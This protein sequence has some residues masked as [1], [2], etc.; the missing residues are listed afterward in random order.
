MAEHNT[1]TGASLHEPKGVETASAKQIYVADGSGGGEWTDIGEAIADSHICVY[2]DPQNQTRTFTSGVVD[3]IIPFSLDY[4][5]IEIRNFTWDNTA[6]ELT[7]TGT[8]N[9][10]STINATMSL[11]LVGTGSPTLKFY[12]QKLNGGVWETNYRSMSA[13]KFTN[14]DVGNLTIG[15]L[16]ELSFGDKVRLAV[17]CDAAETFEAFNLNFYM[18]GVATV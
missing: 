14:N 17:E 11:K 3:T 7:Y 6:K 4:S 9:I 15:C 5:A 10:V 8:T 2:L 13:R 18:T 12:V 16:G 1:L